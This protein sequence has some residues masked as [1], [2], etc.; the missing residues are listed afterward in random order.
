MESI[1]SGHDPV[2][3]EETLHWLDLRP[4]QVVVDCTLGRGGHAREMASRLG[5]EG[6]L[7]GLDVDPRNLEFAQGRL[8]DVPCQVRL[9]HANFAEL[10]DVLE[11]TGLKEVDAILA[12]L[13]ISTNQLFDARYGLSF[14][15]PMPLDMRIDPRLRRSAADIVNSIR[16][17]ALADVLYELAQERYSR[18]IARNIVEARRIS[19]ITTTERLA[20]LVR[21]AYASRGGSHER[22][23]PATR[24]FLALR[25]A[26]NEE[27]PN[28][29][30]LL[31]EAPGFLGNGGRLAIISFQS[32]EDRLVKQA[33]RSAEQTGQ[34]KI[35]TPKPICPTEAETSANPRSR[36]ARLRVMQKSGRS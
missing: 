1:V 4:G 28:L 22:I 15:Q 33:F 11:Q 7:I 26:V 14:A 21:R 10:R 35:L 23:D 32:T 5:R 29:R 12:D 13:G 31:K 6:L 30:A 24:T 18:R 19:P 17:E 9:F 27:I 20:D 3:L 2:L 36:S 34:A 8:K 25:M 16:E